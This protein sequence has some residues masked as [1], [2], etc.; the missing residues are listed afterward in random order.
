MEYIELVKDCKLV[1][2]RRVLNKDNCWG[3]SEY[4]TQKYVIINGNIKNT[5]DDWYV[6]HD[7]KNVIKTTCKTVIESDIR[8]KE[9]KEKTGFET[10]REYA[11][12]LKGRSE[13]ENNEELLQEKIQ[14][15]RK[16]KLDKLKK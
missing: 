10:P 1:K 14:E 2:I 4:Y 5:W 7:G 6:V 11:A 16:K 15:L 12:Y 13:I 8:M 3:N 9:Y